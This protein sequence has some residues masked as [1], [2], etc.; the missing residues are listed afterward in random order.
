[1]PSYLGS[2]T[3]AASSS[4]ASASDASIGVSKLPGRVSIVEPRFGSIGVAADLPEPLLVFGQELDLADPLGTLPRIEFRRDHAAGSAVLVRQGPSFPRVDE[5]D[6]V[7]DRPSERQV[8]RVRDVAA[9]HEVVASAEH[10]VC[11]VAGHRQFGNRLESNAAPVVVVPAPRGHAMKV[12][13]VLSLREGEKGL[14]IER[15]GVFDKPADLK[16]PAP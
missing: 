11:V 8:G 16:P 1:M 10:V 12:A 2:Y 14:P 7:F 9:G 4:G 15:D 3:S 5:Q 6:V 13:D